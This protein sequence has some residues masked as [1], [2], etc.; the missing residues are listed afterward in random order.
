MNFLK[1]DTQFDTL[2]QYK[3]YLQTFITEG[4]KFNGCNIWLGNVN[5]TETIFAHN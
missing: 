1:A 4:E 2:E 5:Q 3:E